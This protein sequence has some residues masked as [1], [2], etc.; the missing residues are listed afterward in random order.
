MANLDAAF[1]PALWSLAGRLSTR[2]EF[3][4]LPWYAESGLNPQA[5]NS[6]G[7]VGL[8]QLDSGYLRRIGVD[9]AEYRLRPASGQ[10]G[11]IEGFLRPLVGLNRGGF[12]SAANAYQ[13][14]FWPASLVRGN[15]PDVVIVSA[16]GPGS[17]PAAYRANSG[18]DFDKNGRI[19]VGDLANHLAKLS[20][21][22]DYKAALAALYAVCP[23]GDTC[24]PVDPVPA[25]SQQ[26]RSIGQ[27]LSLG[28]ALGWGAVLAT[29]FVI[30]YAT[31]RGIKLR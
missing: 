15:G 11:P 27:G 13:A 3:L 8:N 21:N 14:N 25:P 19:T 4:L 20:R 22:G 12:V 24:T 30:F 6:L 2:P 23:P 10:L 26:Q 18:L 1:Y 28:E 16:N 9:P 7:Y 5:L 31:T 29:A 17:E